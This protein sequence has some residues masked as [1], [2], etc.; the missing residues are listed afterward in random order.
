M[1]FTVLG[2]INQ[3]FAGQVSRIIQENPEKWFADAYGS[4][5][6]QNLYAAKRGYL[7]GMYF[8][9]LAAPFRKRDFQRVW[10]EF[11]ELMEETSRHKFRTPQDAFHQIVSLRTIMAGEF[12]PVSMEH[13][14]MHFWAPEKQL[15][16]ILE[17][18]E[19][20]K[21][22]S[23]CINDSPS[24]SW[25]DYLRLKQEIGGAMQRAFPEKSSFEK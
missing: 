2:A 7:P 12:H 9:H 11:P 3:R 6:E 5:A 22:L 4:W 23:I 13:N 21:Y 25:E 10:T 19:Q 14:G 15:D 8:S 1:T 24:V 17:A 16:Q 20:E 18:I